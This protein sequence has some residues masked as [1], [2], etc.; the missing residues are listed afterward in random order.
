MQTEGEETQ[1]QPYYPA[2]SNN[3]KLL[4]LPNEQ[5]A[6]RLEFQ[7]Y[8]AQFLQLG[9][10]VLKSPVENHLYGCQERHDAGTG[11]KISSTCE[12]FHISFYTTQS[13]AAAVVGKFDFCD[14]QLVF[15]ESVP[16]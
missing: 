3:A 11:T 8:Q 15:S 14:E 2:P 4:G 6:V 12:V 5:K 1:T 7:V 9:F 10:Y 13:F 16:V